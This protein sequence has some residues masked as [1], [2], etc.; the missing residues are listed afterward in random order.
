M[1]NFYSKLLIGFLF[2]LGT[3][4]AKAQIPVTVS[5]TGVTSPALAASYPSLALALTDLNAVT[6]YSTPGTIIF[7]CDAGSSETAPATGLVI[8]SATLSPLL[9]A[10]NT[11]TIIKASGTVT[12]NAG[13]GT[14]TPASAAPDGILKLNGADWVTIDGLTLTDGN[15]TNPATMES[16]I[17]FYKLSA[18]DGCSNNTIQNCTINMQRINNAS[19]SAPHVEGAVGIALY[20]STLTAATTVLTVS[21]ASG[22]NSNNKFYTNTINGGNYGIAIIGFAATTPFTLADQNNDVGGVSAGTG[23]QILNYGGGAGATN[24]AAA[25]RTLAQYGLNISYNTIDN[26]NGG[27]ANHATTLRGIYTNTATSASETITNN[28]VTV[29]SGATTSTLTAIDNAAGSTAAGNTI[30]IN[31]NTIRFSYTTATSGVFTAISN[32]AS[33]GTV[34]INSNNIQ[35]LAATNYPS[36]GTVP[37][38]VGGSPGGPMNVTNNTISNFVMTSAAGGTLRA[39]TA[40]T[41][42]GLY[43]VTGN[44]IEN[45]SYT[46]ATSTGNITGIYNLASAALQNVNNNIIRNFSTPTTGTLNGIQ[47]NTVAG[48]FQCKNNQIYNFSTSAGG[49]GGFSSNGITWSNATAEI[50]GNI[51]YSINSTGTT[52]GTGGTLNGITHSGAATVT[53]N[54]IFDISSNSTNVVITGIT[55]NATGTNTVTNNLIGDLRAPNSTGNIAISGML[56]SGGTT[57]NIYHNSVNIASTTTSATTF[58]TSAIYFSSSTP[59][60]NLKNNIFVNTSTPGPTGG[61]ATAI[62]YTIAPTSTNFPASN[63]NNFYYAGVAA[64]NQVIYCEGATAAPTNGQQTIAAY[65]TY[66]N[67]TLPVSGREA[68]SVSESPNWVSTTGSNPVTTFLKYNTTI[69]T[70]IERGGLLGTGVSTDFA[71]TTRCPGGGCP[72]ASATPDMGAWELD[73][74]AADFTAPSISYT[75]LPN[76]ACLTAPSLSATISD[77]SLVNTTAG[78]KPRLYYRRN[79]SNNTYA[80]NTSADNGWKYVE[81]SNAA[82]PFTFTFD[83]SIMFGGA[84]TTGD[85]IQ[86]FVVA[87][88][89]A[90]SINVGI[91]S[92]I[93]NSAAT[94]VDLVSGNFP[95]TGTINSYTLITPGLS[96][97]VTIGA[98]GTY[99]SITGAGGLFSAINTSGLSGNLTANIIDASVTETGET[100]L[101]QIVYTACSGGPFTVT[102]KPDAATTSVLTGSSATALITLN[103]A[104]YVT[105]DGSNSGGSTKDLT[106]ENTATSTNTAAIWVSSLGSG[107]GATNNTIK[108]CNIKAGSN[109]VTSTFGIHVGGTSITTSGTGNDNDNLTIDNNTISKAYYGIYAQAASTGVNNNLTITNNTIGSATAADY[110]TFRGLLVSQATAA[111]VSQNTVFNI[112]AATTNLRGMEFS[113]GFVSSTVSRNLIYNINYTAT[114]FSAGKGMTFN[115]GAGVGTININNNVIYGLKGQGS[116][117]AANNSWGIMLE[118]G[119]AY[120]IYFNS[121]NISDNRT[122]TSSADLHGC[123]YVASAVTVI[124]LRNNVFAMTATA[125]NATTGKTYGIYCLAANTA[126]ST[127]NYNDFYAPG[128]SNRFAG[129]IASDRTTLADIQAGFGQNLNSLVADPIFNTNTNLVPQIGSPLSAVGDN[130]TGITI[131]YNGVTRTNPPTIG[132][133]DVPVD[134]SAPVITYTSLATT[135]ATA[136]RILTA[137]ITDIT[138]V[139]TSGALQPRIYYKKNADAYFS[140]QGLLS[141]GSATNGTWTFTIVAADMGGVTSGD[142]ISYYVIAQDV[143]VVPNITS[144]PATGLVATDV[145]TVSNPPTTPNTYTLQNTLAAGTYTVGASGTYPTLTAAIAAYNNSCLGGP[146]VFSLIDAAY[147]T[148]S[149]T[150]RVN[151]GT[152]ATNTLTIK[153][154]LAGTTITGNT[155]TAAIVFLGADYVTIDGSISNTTNTVCPASS[156]SRDLSIINSNASTA[157]AVIW[158]TASGTDGA[159]NNTIKNCN[160][161]GSGSAATILGIGSGGATIGGAATTAVSNNNSIV[162]NNISRVQIGIY[163]AGIN[164]ASKNNGTVI[165]QNLINSASPDNVSRGGIAAFSENNISVTGNNVSGMALT[166]TVDA[167]GINLGTLNITT[168]STAGLECTNAVISKNIIGSV[169]HTNTYSALGILLAPG[170]TGTSE[171]SNNMV[172]GVSSNGTDGDFSVGIFVLPADGSTTKVYHNTVSM[173]GTQTGGSDKSYALAIAGGTTPTVDIKNNILINKQNNGSGLNY[174]IGF[175]YTAFTN[176]S[177]DNNGLFTSSGALYSLGATSSIGTPVNQL[178][179]AAWQTATSKDANSKNEDATFVSATDLH[180]VTPDANNFNNFESTGAVVSVTDDIDCETRPNGTAPDMGADEF[181]GAIPACPGPGTPVMSSI[182]TNSAIATWTGSGTYILEYGPTGYTPGTGATAG[183]GGTLIDP[184]VSPQSI[185]GLSQTTTYDVYV[186]TVCPRSVW[187][188]NSTVQTFTTLTPP[189]ANDECAAATTINTVSI[190]ATTAASTQTIAPESCAGYTATTANDV[191]FQF[192]ASSNGTATVNVTNVVGFDPVIQ[193][194]SGTCGSLT[195]IGCAD[196]G[197]SGGS[198]VAALAGLVSGQTY[199]VRVYGYT[200]STGTFDISVTG[201]ALPISIEYFKGSKQSNGHQLDWKVTCLNSPTVTL[202]LERSADGRNFKTINSQSA[203]STRCLQPFSF[204][205][206]SPLAGINYYRLKTIDIDGK[207]NYST[208]VALLNKDKGFEIVSIMPNPVATKAML[209]ISSAQKSTMEII[210]TDLAGKQLSKQRVVLLAGS[211]QVSLNLSNLAA[212]SYQ[213]TGVTDEGERKSLRFVKQ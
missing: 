204:T 91:N 109:T 212:G 26:N 58:G 20:N 22:T 97:T 174:A 32:S 56:I 19:G 47:N 202:L 102:I 6:S 120:N 124:D 182:T 67:T 118:S 151:V 206:A 211:N 140:S 23:N 123:M 183:V 197:T 12:L 213:V 74:A 104:D 66:I 181:V 36:T 60:N 7:T 117:T 40:S 51:I 13:V 125:G 149:D 81:A 33:A 93:F 165:S 105:I 92:G 200:S 17:S 86:Y 80:G 45:L 84:P 112:V 16:G 27:G 178:T 203:T 18:T 78:T 208:I 70:Q 38:I 134:G 59:V 44:T 176:I 169:R 159:N 28:T 3:M 46:T 177:T 111:T 106:I 126:F 99:T 135:C 71:G 157:S 160:I 39:I 131:D 185:T 141:S 180:L 14:A 188:A 79:T 87:Q 103:G 114:S 76:T 139:P 8:G 90:P 62:R 166:T 53:G 9:S 54:S 15:A 25:I 129:F 10:T 31:S 144:N 189:P 154:T 55:T 119:T 155:T 138:G 50:S 187:S 145:N 94:S 72:G 148:T 132:S 192:T 137:T 156:A 162:N 168:S 143:V 85:T 82:S 147:T 163:S 210:V 164:A 198:E 191:W 194:Y 207:I 61:F 115:P 195:N 100:A 21:A 42:T 37:V 175:G 146:V 133:Y 2:F 69:A 29:R 68:A 108:N 1:K 130:S 150:I 173:S 57:N 161:T 172:S 184:A 116:G 186:R 170:S 199:Y 193:V 113:T 34:N 89:L 73:G 209:S 136:D 49:A 88:D 5:G 101:N 167:F 158:M 41:P 52:G 96:G 179:L 122:A 142:V 95:L 98:A 77:A 127:I 75:N 83:Y 107:L 171:I 48:T 121:V 65:K 4:D 11:V 43:T 64:A 63:N 205:D 196:L 128:T 110:I 24:P 201:A 190:A 30:S 35:Q 153:P 152:S